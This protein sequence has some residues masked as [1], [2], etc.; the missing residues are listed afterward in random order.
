MHSENIQD[1]EIQASKALLSI[2]SIKKR[3]NNICERVNRD[4]KNIKLVAVSKNQTMNTVNTF[5]NEGIF[6]FGENRLQESQKKW[7][8]IIKKEKKIELHFI[9]KLQ[10]KKVTNVLN[11]FQTIESIDNEK[12]LK[13]IA[14]NTNE[15]NKNNFSFFMQ[16]NI[17]QEPQ[18]SGVLPNEADDFLIM[19]K[20]KYNINISGAMG[21]API[22]KQ[23]A[24]YFSLL[25]DFCKKN[26]LVNVSMGMSND[27]EVAIELGATNIRIGSGLFGERIE[28]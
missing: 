15:L 19:A 13:K 27:F 4:P 16:I 14:L 5:V 18:K 20:E 1:E 7:P 8:A 6:V 26:K 24:P 25:K 12:L 23:A 10:T 21:I 17:G 28:K 22:N 2:N 11:L 9:G 3:I